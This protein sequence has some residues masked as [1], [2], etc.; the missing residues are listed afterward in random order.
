MLLS[1]HPG[2]IA[3]ILV[4]S[5]ALVVVVM[6]FAWKSGVCRSGN[7]RRAKYK[8]VSKFFP[9]SY[10]QGEASQVAMPELGLPKALPAEREMLLNDSDED[11]L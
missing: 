10:S 4:A 1:N 3:L 8:S 7:R 9:F 11:E 5:L 2:Y 6:V